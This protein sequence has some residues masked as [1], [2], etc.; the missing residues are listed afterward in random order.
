MYAIRASGSIGYLY[1]AARSICAISG[2]LL[3]GAGV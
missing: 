2:R 3:S 1:S